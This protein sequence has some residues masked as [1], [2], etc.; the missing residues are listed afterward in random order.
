M[1]I[2]K[3]IA[4][5]TTLALMGTTMSL[6]SIISANAEESVGNAWLCFTNGMAEQWKAGELGEAVE[7]TGNGSYSLSINLDE[8]QGAESILLLLISTDINIYEEDENGNKLY[9]DMTFSVDSISIDGNEVEYTGPSAGAVAT[10]NDG[11]SYRLNILNTW[12]NSVEDIDANVVNTSNITVNFTVSG[13][14]YD[15]A[16]EDTTV[17]TTVATSEDT[18]IANT[19]EDVTSDTVSDIVV[20]TADTT[21]TTDIIT[22]T[23]AISTD[24]TSII[25]AINTNTATTK[26]FAVNYTLYNDIINNAGKNVSSNGYDTVYDNLGYY[27][28]DINND[29]VEE[30]IIADNFESEYD[31]TDNVNYIWG[32]YDI[33]TIKDGKVVEIKQD[34][35]GE[36]DEADKFFEVARDTYLSLTVVDGKLAYVWIDE[37][38]DTQSLAFI[39]DGYTELE[40]GSLSVEVTVEDTTKDECEELQLYKYTDK[41]VL[42]KL[43]GTINSNGGNGNNNNSDSDTDTD[44]S[45]SPDTGDTGLGAVAVTFAV[46]GL[47]ALALKKKD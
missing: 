33:Y 7:I 1:N 9:D 37:E 6:G 42:N 17:D 3:F 39:I 38:D 13:L 34:V 46:A 15:K 26:S 2:K 11:S 27:L 20:T 18:T 16:S 47:S 14:S 19:S 8:T 24:A 10:E 40:D 41:T 22:S 25:T 36:L 12:G 5:I 4:S 45:D 31:S 44:T 21:P 43:T 29:G 23:D 32:Y 35:M 28:F 30:L